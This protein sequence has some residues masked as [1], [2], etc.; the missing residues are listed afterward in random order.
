MTTPLH[1]PRCTCHKVLTKCE[2]CNR[3]Y[4]KRCDTFSSEELCSECN[5]KKPFYDLHEKWYNDLLQQKSK[6][7]IYLNAHL[8]FLVEMAYTYI[9]ANFVDKELIFSYD[10]TDFFSKFENYYHNTKDTFNTSSFGENKGWVE[11]FIKTELNFK[12][13]TSSY[14]T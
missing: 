14:S 10:L 2:I 5:V 12:G 9:G 4:C 1:I 8:I 3:L 13:G 6:K 11:R 7:E